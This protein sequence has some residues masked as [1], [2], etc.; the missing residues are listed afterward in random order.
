MKMYIIKNL[1]INVH[2]SFNQ[3]IPNRKQLKCSSVDRRV[4]KPSQ[5]SIP[6]NTPQ[7]SKLSMD[8]HNN[9]DDLKGII[10][11]GKKTQQSQ[12]VDTRLIPFM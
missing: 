2:R 11:N 9:L 1:Q 3:N 8:A 5:I 4:N 7:Q 12:K 10:L 6:L